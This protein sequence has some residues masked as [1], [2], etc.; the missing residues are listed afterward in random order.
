MEKQKYNLA[1]LGWQVLTSEGGGGDGDGD[2]D[3]GREYDP[4]TMV[5]WAR[6]IRYMLDSFF[7]AG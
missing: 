1:G 7:G 2:G 4:M 3:G 6:S 5:C